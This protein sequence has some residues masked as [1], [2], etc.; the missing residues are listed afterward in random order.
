MV[1]AVFAASA[2]QGC[3]CSFVF[4]PDG[5]VR[6]TPMHLGYAYEDVTFTASDGVRLTGWWIPAEGAR[7]TVLFFHGNGGNVSH[8]LDVAETCT[9]LGLNVFLFDYRGYGLSSG[10]PS[11]QG[12]YLDAEAAYTYLVDQRRLEGDM[13]V[14][15]GRS[16]GGALACRLAS[17]RACAAVVLESSFVSVPRVA[18]D[19]HAWLPCSL[20]E[21][22]RFDTLDFLK[23]VRSPVLV[24][25][26][27]EDEIVPFDHGRIL[28][29][30]AS[31][32]KEFVVIHGPHN[33]GVF[34]SRQAYIQGLERFFATYLHAREGGG[35]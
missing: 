10:R 14:L 22:C 6:K 20:F 30:S 21:D 32:L 18:R 12:L 27:P 33:S 15:W 19:H 35:R 9:M 34:L 5:I 8:C 17:E 26:S 1:L 11:E 4:Q 7:A 31:G 23:K 29:S 3:V 13:I 28:F 24:I 16:L 2:L 25:H